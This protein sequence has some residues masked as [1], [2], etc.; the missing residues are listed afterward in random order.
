MWPIGRCL[1]PGVGGWSCSLEEEDL[2]PLAHSGPQPWDVIGL[3]AN[4]W[5]ASRSS[6]SGRLH[7]RQF[8]SRGLSQVR[9]MSLLRQWLRGSW[10]APSSDDRDDDRQCSVDALLA[11]W[12]PL[13]E[14]TPW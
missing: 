14:L 7:H 6:H 12:S 2:L 5:T 11:L 10:T 1:S 8:S 3:S 13:R 9:F 4:K